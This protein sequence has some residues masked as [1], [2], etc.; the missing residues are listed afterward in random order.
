[1]LSSLRVTRRAFMTR[2][3][4]FWLFGGG[5]TLVFRNP[6]WACQ[7]LNAGMGLDRNAVI[8]RNQLLTERTL[9]GNR[10]LIT[11]VQFI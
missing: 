4:E 1:M 8:M 7:V 3:L 10:I 5:E 11:V 2:M 9:R 6:F